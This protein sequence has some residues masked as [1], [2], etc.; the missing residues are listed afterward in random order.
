MA[1]EKINKQI[2]VRVKGSED[3]EIEDAFGRFSHDDYKNKNDFL[4][5]A[6][7][8]GARQIVKAKLIGKLSK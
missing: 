4:R 8:L 2:G 6:L 3:M 1:K 7:L 5:E